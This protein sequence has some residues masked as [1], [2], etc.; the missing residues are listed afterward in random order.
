MIVILMGQMRKKEECLH[1]NEMMNRE[2]S[3]KVTFHESEV[4]VTSP[5]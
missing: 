3:G 1:L 4:L 2:W 5:L